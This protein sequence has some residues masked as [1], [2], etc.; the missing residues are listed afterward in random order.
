MHMKKFMILASAVLMLFAGCIRRTK[1]EHSSAVEVRTI[2][3]SGSQDATETSYIGT[4]R[5]SK[6]AHIVSRHDG[7]LK[8]ILVRKG[9]HVAEGQVI[10]VIE[11]QSLQSAYNAAKASLN[12]AE[13]AM[14]RVRRVHDANVVPDMKMVEIETKLQQAKAAASA[15]E[16]ALEEC[17]IRAP[18]A[19]VVSEI[20]TETGISVSPIDR[21]ATIIDMH[22]AEIEFA[23]PESEISDFSI[24]DTATVGISAIGHTCQ[25]VV[26]TKDMVSS[27]LSHTFM[28]RLRPIAKSADM[29]PGMVCHIY[30][31]RKFQADI[32]IPA[33]AVK[34]DSHGKYVWTVSADSIVSKR[35]ITLGEFVSHGVMVLDGLTTGDRIIVEGM[36]K[37]CT[38]MKVNVQQ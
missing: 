7:K 16:H 19:G 36:Q 4:V 37:V 38:G 33:N 3:V 18:F 20:V 9:T 5:P 22:N 8:Q 23:V 31:N 30:S 27:P 1:A 29:M 26:V 34:M 32:V 13:D 14:K 21:I 17:R 25:A 24:G 28:C 15:A 10:A 35:Y 2:L 11:S 12:E 6:E